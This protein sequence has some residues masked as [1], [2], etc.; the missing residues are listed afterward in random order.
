MMMMSNFKYIDLHLKYAGLDNNKNMC[1]QGLTK[2][3]S[4]VYLELQH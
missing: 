3:L 4:K 1:I 2:P